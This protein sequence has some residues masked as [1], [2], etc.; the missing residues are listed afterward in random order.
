M[1][2]E[3]P[4]AVPVES[5][6]GNLKIL[7]AED[8]RSAADILVLFFEM[9]GH[10]VSV[11]Y[12]GAEAVEIALSSRPHLILM[13]IGMPKLSGLEAV[14]KI[15]ESGGG[16]IVIVALSGLDSIADRQRSR[17]AGF[18]EHLAKPVSPDELR[19]LVERYRVVGRRELGTC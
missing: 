3:S 4:F 9:E 8:G 12:D 13:D 11:A 14:Q 16:D 6:P 19:A 1:I 5:Q 17:D 2:S 7:V 18:D 15:R 10:E